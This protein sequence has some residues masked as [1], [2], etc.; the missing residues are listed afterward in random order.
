MNGVIPTANSCS[1]KT[2]GILEGPANAHKVHVVGRTITVFDSDRDLRV[3]DALC[4]I[5]QNFVRSEVIVTSV[6]VTESSENI[7][8]VG[9]DRD[10]TGEFDELVWRSER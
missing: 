1:L 10:V 3:G 6:E 9:L 5:G 8:T 4:L 7:F 2:A